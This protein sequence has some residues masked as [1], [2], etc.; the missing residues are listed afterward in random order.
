MTPA[1]QIIDRATRRHMRDLNLVSHKQVR[2]ADDGRCDVCGSV[3]N[4]AEIIERHC[5]TCAEVRA[6]RHG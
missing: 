6:V 4:M 5:I 1:E 2:P 3:L